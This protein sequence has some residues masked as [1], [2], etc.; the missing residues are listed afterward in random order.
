MNLKSTPLPSPAFMHQ[1][2]KKFKDR[3]IFSGIEEKK[4]EFKGKKATYLAS[5]LIH[6]TEMTNLCFY[7]QSKNSKKDFEVAILNFD[8]K[9]TRDNMISYLNVIGNIQVKSLKKFHEYFEETGD[10]KRLKLILV[11]QYVNKLSLKTMIASILTFDGYGVQEFFKSINFKYTVILS[12]W[13]TIK[14]LRA[15]GLQNMGISSNLVFFS[16]TATKYPQNEIE[17]KFYDLFTDP[18]INIEYKFNH[19]R[20]LLLADAKEEITLK[21]LVDLNYFSKKF[22]EKFEVLSEAFMDHNSF[23]VLV[24][25]VALLDNLDNFIDDVDFISGY[26]T[27]QIK[28]RIDDKFLCGVIEDCFADRHKKIKKFFTHENAKLQNLNKIKNFYQAPENQPYY[29]HLSWDVFLRGIKIISKQNSLEFLLA[30]DESRLSFEQLSLIAREHFRG[31]LFAQIL[32]I[33]QLSDSSLLD[34]LYL[35]RCFIYYFMVL[36]E[37]SEFTNPF[38]LESRDLKKLM[39]ICLHLYQQ[40]TENNL[41]T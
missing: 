8:A 19:F 17:K 13:E 11:D 7:C 35:V 36:M 27:I 28:D 32:E 22:C 6:N 33:L 23:V 15:R 24:L 18:K 38:E 5:K 9:K 14:E 37:S 25:E 4:I 39:L 12:V 21:E 20:N 10:G 2:T 30:L 1:I 40:G 29:E 31:E 34:Q 3:N 26:L 16:D 41:I